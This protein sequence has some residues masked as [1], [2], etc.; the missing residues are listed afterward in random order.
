M[1]ITLLTYLVLFYLCAGTLIS[2]GLLRASE[3][4][5]KF[6]VIHGLAA[7]AMAALNFAFMGREHATYEGWVW[8]L[9]FVIFFTLYCLLI[10]RPKYISIPLFFLGTLCA[11]FSILIDLSYLVDPSLY[12]AAVLNSVLSTFFLGFTMTAMLLGHWYLNQPKMSGD[13]LKRVTIAFLVLVALRFLVATW[14]LYQLLSPMTEAEIYK[15]LAGTTQGIFVLMRYFWGILGP[16]GLAYLIWGTVKIRSTQS[17]TGILYVAVVFVLIGEIISQ[18]L[19]FFH[20][21]AF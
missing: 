7:L 21:I 10:N 6:Y 15:A 8:F 2:F 11:T 17:A 20:G 12:G 4:G 13:E 3:V 16:L 1:S 5:R 14:G 9:G 18:Y 19:T